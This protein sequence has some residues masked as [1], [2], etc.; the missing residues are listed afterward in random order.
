MTHSLRNYEASFPKICTGIA[1][2]RRR[3]GLPM[4]FKHHVQKRENFFVDVEKT[5]I[6]LR[7]KSIIKYTVKY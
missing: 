5:L 3:L 2:L 7:L 1:T 4:G 6:N